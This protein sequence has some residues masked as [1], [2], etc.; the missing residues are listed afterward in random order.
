M[1]DSGELFRRVERRGECI[2]RKLTKTNGSASTVY[3]RRG[4]IRHNLAHPL[5]GTHF[6]DQTTDS[7]FTGC[8]CN[9]ILSLPL[10]MPSK[11][12]HRCRQTAAD[13]SLQHRGRINR[14]KCHRPDSSVAT[15]QSRNPSHSSAGCQFGLLPAHWRRRLSVC[16]WPM[17]LG[18]QRS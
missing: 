10:G 3:K 9:R 11:D 8:P 18:L 5:K 17:V 12:S 6:H 15:W 2:P 13:A 7:S 16:A 4:R 14:E 1:R